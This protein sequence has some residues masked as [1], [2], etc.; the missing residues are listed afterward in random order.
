VARKPRHAPAAAAPA[1]TP[2]H[3]RRARWDWA[4]AAISFVLMAW[5]VTE[6][7]WK[8]FTNSGFLESFYD[9]QARSLLHGRI[10]VPAEAI[11]SE[12]FVRNGKA[13]G[14]FGPTPALLR[15]PLLVLFPGTY[16]LWS[17]GSMLLAAAVM[18][19]SLLLLFRVLER[20][21]PALS[22]SAAWRLLAPALIFC[23]AFGSSHFYVFAEAKLYYESIVWGAALSFAAAVCIARYLTG[24]ETRWLV[25]SCATAL[26][27]FFARVSSGAGPI[28]ALLLVAAALWLPAGQAALWRPDMAGP[29]R[30]RAIALLTGTV[31]LTAVLWAALNY[32]KFG[33]A[34]TSQPIAL[35]VQYTPERLQRVKGELASLTNLPVTLTSYFS[36]ANIRFVRAFPWVEM[37]EIPYARVAARFPSAHLDRVEQFAS[38]P[39]AMPALLGAALAGTLLCLRRRKQFGPFQA[40]MLGSIA[41]CGLLFVWGLLTYRYLHDMFPWL[42]LGTAIAL[43]SLA[44]VD[45]RP[46]RLALTALF[47]TGTVYGMWVNMSFGLFQQRLLSWTSPPEKRFG[48]ADL[49]MSSGQGGLGGFLSHLTRWRAYRSA[50][51]FE[52]GNLGVDKLQFA[53]AANVPVL[54]STGA[55]PYGVEYS[56]AVPADGEYELSIRY[57]SP[58]PRPVLLTIEGRTVGYVCAAGTGGAEG[59]FQRW[60]FSGRH[61]LTRG[62]VRL[63]LLAKQAFPHV[64]MLRLVRTQ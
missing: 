15:M 17:R 6:G 1:E 46:L 51:S 26:L 22:E 58:E 14:Y 62:N 11:G 36:P 50:A 52:A 12:A 16:G 27:A 39:A 53:E 64:S 40:P 35:N 10:D 8:F 56:F 31:L 61:R 48:F 24:G 32:W 42:V 57:A 30:R 25:L 44:T 5:F 49:A 7:D 59:R 54:Y 23:A 13:Y 33:R 9:A 34:F 45:R 37:V 43:A 28:F 38:L 20:Q 2:R 4:A 3:A 63:Q 29:A 41:G 60:V 19:A 47:V 18:L 55:P 21:A